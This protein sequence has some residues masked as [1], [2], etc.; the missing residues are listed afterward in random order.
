MKM[1]CGERHVM[2]ERAQVEGDK[3]FLGEVA[4]AVDAEDS[5]KLDIFPLPLPP[6]IQA[7][8]RPR[9]V[10]GEEQGQRGRDIR[11]KANKN[12]N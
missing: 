12:G 1:S 6:I 11:E 4:R 2:G 5:Y 9:R 7:R 8:T 10:H 3:L